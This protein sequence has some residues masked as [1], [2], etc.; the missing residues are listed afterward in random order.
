MMHGDT[1]ETRA[2]IGAVLDGLARLPILVVGAAPG[3]LMGAGFGALS[4]VIAD[5]SLRQIPSRR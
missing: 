1:L 3:A 4:W 5:Q 2:V